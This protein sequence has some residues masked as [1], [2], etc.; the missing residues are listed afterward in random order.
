MYDD[1]NNNKQATWP[2]LLPAGVEELPPL[3]HSLIGHSEYCWD[4]EPDCMALSR[5]LIVSSAEG[6]PRRRHVHCLRAHSLSL[7]STGFNVRCLEGT[8]VYC[9][10]PVAARQHDP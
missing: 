6:I 4:W 7:H 10:E 2:L 3:F 9:K 5:E 1:N 8:L